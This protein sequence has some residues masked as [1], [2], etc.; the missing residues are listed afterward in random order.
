MVASF[1]RD[2]DDPATLPFPGVES[3]FQDQAG[4]MWVGGFTI[5]LCK[6]DQ[7]RLNFGHYRTRAHVSSFF[8]D[9]DGTL[10]VGS[11]NDGLYKYER[12]S[13]RV[14]VYRDIVGD[15]GSVRSAGREGQE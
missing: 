7:L 3:I 13:Q 4:V 12:A 1:M 15:A 9:P 10:W 11:Y 2:P 6:F 5:G 8:E 14:T